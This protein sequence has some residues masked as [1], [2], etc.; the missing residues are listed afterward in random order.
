MHE[1]NVYCIPLP[2]GIDRPPPLPVR[3]SASV[4]DPAVVF[5][6]VD[7]WTINQSGFVHIRD[8]CTHFGLGILPSEAVFCATRLLK[9]KMET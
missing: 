1:K 8:P 5:H 9:A 2:G 7:V 3:A 4:F 6:P